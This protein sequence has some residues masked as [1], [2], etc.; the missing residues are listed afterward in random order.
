MGRAERK[1]PL[2]RLFYLIAEPRV[3]RLF[4]MLIYLGFIWAGLIIWLTPS[5]S[6]QRIL[7][8]MLV[9]VFGGFMVIGGALGAVAV[10]PGIWWLE[11]AGIV[12]I[13]TGLLIY[14]VFILTLGI[15]GLGFVVALIL[16]LCVVKR[17]TEIRKFQVAPALP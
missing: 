9:G 10:L 6:L 5:E 12:G 17:W 14:M 16:V 4:Q 15:T 2:T 11:R 1:D 3:V 7:G 13:V 8:G